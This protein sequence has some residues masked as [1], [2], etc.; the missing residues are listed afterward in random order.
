LI[1]EDKLKKLEQNIMI[2]NNNY[3]HVTGLFLLKY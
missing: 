2:M 1:F 3:A